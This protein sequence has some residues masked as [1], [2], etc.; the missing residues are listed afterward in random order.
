MQSSVFQPSLRSE[1]VANL[2]I[3]LFHNQ[4]FLLEVSKG[5]KENFTFQEIKGI[6]R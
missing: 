4:V 1:R 5:Q 2:P 6:Y 3:L